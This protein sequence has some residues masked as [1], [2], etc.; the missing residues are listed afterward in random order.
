MT[1]N[2]VVEAA[3]MTPSDIFNASVASSAIGAAW[4]AGALDELADHDKLDIAEFAERQDLDPS[5]VEG[6]FQALAS[7]RIVQRSAGMVFPDVNFAEV[8]RAKAFYHWLSRGSAALFADMPAVL[9]NENRTGQ[10]YRRDSSAIAVACRDINANFFDPVFHGVV[11][12]LEFTKIADLGCGSGERIISVLRGNPDTTGLGIDIAEGALSVAE[13]AVRESGFDDR[14]SFILDDATA[15]APHAEFADVDLLTSFLM[16]HDLWPRDNCVASLRRLRAAFPNVRRFLLG[17][18][19]RT[20]TIPDSEIPV[21]TLGFE[22]AHRMMGVYLPTLQEWR[23]VFE[24]GGWRLV[25]EHRVETPADSVIFELE[26]L[27][28]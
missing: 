11:D 14:I 19:A 7:V 26:P 4:E 18:T 10:F 12:K 2:M 1:E 27:A 20:T 6:M 15:P 23:G 28:S 3:R 24:E 22:V 21:F 25:A 16:G 5:A 17:D 8:F 13:E 9:R